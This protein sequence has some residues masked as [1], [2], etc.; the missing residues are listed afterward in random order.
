[1]DPTTAERLQRVSGKY[2]LRLTHIGRKTGQPHEVTIWFVFDGERM[3]LA[4]ANVNR[5][6]IKNVMKTPRVK[7]SV[8]GENFEGEVRFINDAAERN[9][10]LDKFRRKY[11]IY[12]PAFVIGVAAQKLG[13]VR[14]TMGAFELKVTG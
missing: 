14:N 5:Q 1:M 8:A 11:W 2:T 9:R 7:L 6:W 4:T 12:T 13:L 3:Y 10:V